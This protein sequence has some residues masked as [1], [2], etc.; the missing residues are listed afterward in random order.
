MY[1]RI[2]DQ[3]VLKFPT[4]H[5]SSS[6]SRAE[7]VNERTG[8]RSTCLNVTDSCRNE[9]HSGTAVPK[10][11]VTGARW[12]L[13]AKPALHTAQEWRVENESLH[14]CNHCTSEGKRT[15]VWGFLSMLCSVVVKVEPTLERTLK[16]QDEVLAVK[17][18]HLFSNNGYI[19]QRSC[20]AT[21]LFGSC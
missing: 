5:S 3:V 19:V 11:S 10:D 12:Q 15:C 18:L 21:W 4:L 8:G 13:L 17:T 1:D 7:H 6:T 9:S 14:K 20:K 2:L 16:K